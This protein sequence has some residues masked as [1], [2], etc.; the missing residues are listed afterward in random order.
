MS[1]Q[2]IDQKDGE[3]LLR[4]L[5]KMAD[6]PGGKQAIRFILNSAGSVPIVGGAIAG[7]SAILS[8]REQEKFNQAILDWAAQSNANAA[9]LRLRMDRIWQE[10]TRS[11]LALLLGE[12]FGDGIASELVERSPSQIAVIL[13]PATVAELQPYVKKGWLGLKPTGSLMAMGAGNSIGNYFEELKNP[14]GMGASF[15][16]FLDIKKI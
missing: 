6:M 15:I 11:S 5:N 7:V 12:I 4:R 2:D 1:E 3:D 9:D 8:E 13:N 16:L 14:Y 10:P